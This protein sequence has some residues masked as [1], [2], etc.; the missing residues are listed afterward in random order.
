MNPINNGLEYPIIGNR[1][2]GFAKPVGRMA[3]GSTTKPVGRMGLNQ[4]GFVTTQNMVGMVGMV[5][6]D[7]APRFPVNRRPTFASSLPAHSSDWVRPQTTPPQIVQM[8]GKI[9]FS[10]SLPARGTTWQG[11]GWA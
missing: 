4:G 7:T 6:F 3:L 11:K 10:S 5:G 9:G 8:L 1:H 2:R